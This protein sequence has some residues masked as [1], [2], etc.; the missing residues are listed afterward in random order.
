MQ[1]NM[2]QSAPSKEGRSHWLLAVLGQTPAIIT[3]I[4]WWL[5]HE[6]D[7]PIEKVIIWT[8]KDQR[9]LDPGQPSGKS[10]LTSA[11][12]DL[13][14]LMATLK[15]PV[16]VA[17]EGIDFRLI[18][19]NGVPLDDIRD[20]ADNRALMKTIVEDVANITSDNED[21]VL[22]ACISGGRKT[23]SAMLQTA[24][25]LFGRHQDALY[26]VLVHPKIESPSGNTLIKSFQ[27]PREDVVNG[28]TK[29]TEHRDGTTETEVIR[30]PLRDQITVVAQPVPKLRGLL[31][32]TLLDTIHTL[33]VADVSIPAERMQQKIVREGLDLSGFH[34][35]SKYMQA[36]LD[37]VVS[38]KDSRLNIVITG[39][40][41]TGKKN[42]ASVIQRNSSRRDQPAAWIDCGKENL[43]WDEAFDWDG[44]IHVAEGGWLLLVNIHMLNPIQQERLRDVLSYTLREDLFPRPIRIIATSTVDL[45][46]M[47]TAGEFDQTLFSI[48]HEY[49]LHLPPLRERPD[50]VAVIA[51]YFLNMRRRNLY[52]TDDCVAP[53]MG[54]TDEAIGFLKNCQWPENLQQ[55]KTAI[56]E[57][58]VRAGNATLLLP[59]HFSQDLCGR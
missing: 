17:L 1:N 21:V 42:L 52:E 50:D 2:K 58:M 20:E 45:Q 13:R 56:D 59:E 14:D 18:T 8:T 24:I 9:S 55:L 5:A 11:W 47:V 40:P 3:E 19:R 25:Q 7:I 10:Y 31:S 44:M 32:G 57:A 28:V 49:T 15:K 51:R 46:S 43:R 37:E 53:V 29:Q 27:F 39:E 6:N 54:I 34:C 23:M 36:L 16:P 41:Y 30:L 48:L 33:M 12:Q 38:V 4:A 35:R 26:H 22:H